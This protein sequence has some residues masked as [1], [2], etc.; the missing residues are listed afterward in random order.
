M[1]LL[2]RL[3]REYRGNFPAAP[4]ESAP[5]HVVTIPSTDALRLFVPWT[6]ADR[7]TKRA[8]SVAA[9]NAWNSLTNDIRNTNNSLLDFSQ[10]TETFYARLAVSM[11]VLGTNRRRASVD[12]TVYVLLC[13]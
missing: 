7:D 5:M 9:P 12:W 3:F 4:V 13:H 1:I 10:Q 6:R 8:F 11:R 2:P